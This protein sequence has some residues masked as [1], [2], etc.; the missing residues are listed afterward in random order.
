MS[1]K[2]ETPS[3][4]IGKNEW[5]LI[6]RPSN[7]GPGLCTEYEWRKPGEQYWRGQRSFQRYD[8][9]DS[10]Y[11]LPISIAKKIYYPNLAAIE[12]ALKGS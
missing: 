10:N 8:F 6:V 11:G 3:V 4:K 2:L 7:Y 12:A 1:N 9:N 5:R